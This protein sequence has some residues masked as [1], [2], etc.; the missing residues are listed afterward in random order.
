ML[1]ATWIA[2]TAIATTGVEAV[3]TALTGRIIEACRAMGL[4][5]P[6]MSQP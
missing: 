3:Y 5:V 1:N 2:P 4:P 6:A